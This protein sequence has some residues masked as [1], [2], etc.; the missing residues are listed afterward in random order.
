MRLTALPL[1]LV[2]FAAGPATAQIVIN[3]SHQA[4]G[5]Q[6]ERGAPMA[7]RDWSA[8]LDRVHHDT[9]QAREAGDLSRREARSIH[10][11]EQRIRA[12]GA[13]YAANGL[14]E[15]ELSTLETQAL[16]LR[17][18]SQAPNRPVTPAGRGR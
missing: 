1:A 5:A 10:R 13:R 8:Q 11:Q 4:S 18:L 6:Q 15:A 12:L 3:G 7:R 2:L 16:L 9:N 17:S 14:T